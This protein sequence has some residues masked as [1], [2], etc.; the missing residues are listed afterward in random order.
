MSA[1]PNAHLL[2]GDMP[3]PRQFESRWWG[4]PALSIATHVL[5]LAALLYAVTH[6]SQVATLVTAAATNR[7]LVFLPGG[8]GSR[9][10][11]SERPRPAVIPAAR[12]VNPTTPIPKPADIPTPDVIVAMQTTQASQPLPGTLSPLDVPG[13]GDRGGGHGT[14]MD[15]GGP[16]PGAGPGEG[17]NHGGGPRQIGNGVTS[18]VLLHEVRPNYTGE[19][20]RAKL[21]GS[22]EMAAVVRPDGT[23][24]PNSIKI[25]R[26]LDPTFGLDQQAII[27]VRQWRFRPGTLNG[28]PIAVIVNVELTFTLR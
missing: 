11:P 24:D 22:V 16:G 2:V 12:P 25:T 3:A 4:G 8:G 14:G 15:G 9:P 7:S 18:P 28:L 27:A 21:Q 23:V 26:S 13:T 17:G 20:M 19:A 10:G 1:S 5:G 6:V